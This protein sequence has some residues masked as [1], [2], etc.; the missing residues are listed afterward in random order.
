[1]TVRIEGLDD[2]RRAFNTLEQPD[3]VEQALVDAVTPVAQK[4]RNRAALHSRSLQSRSRSRSTGK[5]DAGLKV[6]KTKRKIGVRSSA[7]GAGAQEFGRHY[8][9]RS[10]GGDSHTVTMHSPPARILYKAAG[11]LEGEITPAVEAAM[12]QVFRNLGFEVH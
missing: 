3:R 7:P 11:E 6:F 10:K 4:I 8:Q 9:R 2:L 12:D 5:I 1:M